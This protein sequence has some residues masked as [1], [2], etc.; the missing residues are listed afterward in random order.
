M[1]LNRTLPVVS[2]PALSLASQVWRFR[3]C[4]GDAAVRRAHPEVT[5]WMPAHVPGSTH[6][7][8]FALKKIPDPYHD[9]N[10]LDLQ[11]ID[12]L[13]WEFRCDVDVGADACTRARQELVCEGLDSV[14]TVRVNGTVVGRSVN[15]FR[16]VV[17]D[18]RGVLK[19]GR[20]EVVVHLASPTAH[21][22]AQVA[23]NPAH[24]V[25]QAPRLRGNREFAWQTGE[26]R[27]TNRPWIRKVQCHFGWD[28]GVCLPTQGIWRDAR[29]DAADAPRI[30][31]VRVAQRHEGP[32]GAPT[33]VS[34]A[35]SVELSHAAPASGVVVVTCGGAVAR[36]PATLEAAGGATVLATLAIVSPRLWWPN[37]YGAQPLYDLS[38]HWE[39]G[40]APCRRRIGL[41]TLAVET[42]ADQTPE[43]RPAESLTVVVNGRPIFA[44]GGNWIPPDQ[45]VERCTPAVYRHLLESMAESHMNMVRVWGGGWYELDVFYD[46]CDELGLLV[47]QDFMMACALYPDTESF[48]A[49]IAAEAR[50]QVRRLQHHACVALWC[51]DNEVLTGVNHWWKN[52]DA[53]A[54][55]L[56]GYTRLMQALRATVNA[57]DPTRHFRVSSP[58]NGWIDPES[59]SPDRG[60][61]HYW[62]VWHGR[63]PFSNYLT[64][65]PRFCSEF[66]FQAFAEPRTMRACVPR[67]GLNPS[68]WQMEHHQRSPDGNQMIAN[69]I[70][71]ELPVPRDFD[72]YC[73]E[74]QIN[75]A[76]AIRTAVEHWRRLKP[77][78]GGT[79]YWQIND[80]WPVASWSSIDWHGRWKALQHAA[81][82]FFAPLLLS[83]THEPGGG[84][85]GVWLTSD[86]DRPLSLKG[87]LV[88]M[89]WDGRVV[90]R[91][92]LKADI[93]ADASR[94]V[95]TVDVARLLGG[96]AAP[97]DVCL[98][99]DVAGGGQRART[100]LALVPWKHVAL[101]RPRFRASLVQAAKGLELRFTT[102]RI[103]AFVHAEIA[104][105]ESHFAGS[106]DVIRPGLTYRWPLVEHRARGQ[107][108]LRVGA[109]RKRLRLFSLY[110]LAWRELA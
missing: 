38:V 88:A 95:A 44:K 2:S 50:D 82:R 3:A 86:V 53:A 84:E 13:D 101:P 12:Q 89:T 33:R 4:G 39:G 106:F 76:S 23:A 80:L 6:G 49:E 83:L 43:G 91:V 104:D 30:G 9:R 105:S 68:S 60:D 47:W 19:P 11:W 69:A 75:Q 55:I 94:Q 110:D 102:D 71:R 98:F 92:A 81:T 57:E 93:G 72:A 66:G 100:H 27:L 97:R 62:A 5:R 87:A 28:W 59:E 8:L 1:S 48:I 14:A 61:V 96:K 85:V 7:Q 109:A 99:A 78:C 67:E 41:R 34:L 108:P 15:M 107:A 18:L 37:G 54:G 32:A 52:S 31:A 74:S 24:I 10:E 36:V 51:G 45:F 26:K 77:W 21:G 25:S 29:L 16:Q 64:V 56:Q 58:S 70:A 65:R 46:L 79:L 40:G 17:C 22:A 90:G 103:A 63:Q 35:V 20:N 42:V 73:W